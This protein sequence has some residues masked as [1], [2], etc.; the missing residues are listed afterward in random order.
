MLGQPGGHCGWS[1]EGR[2]GWAEMEVMSEAEAT[3]F[4]ARRGVWARLRAGKLTLAVWNER[5][6]RLLC[7]EQS[8][9]HT[10]GGRDSSEDDDW[11]WSVL[12]WIRV[13]AVKMRRED[14]IWEAFWK[15]CSQ[16]LLADQIGLKEKEVNRE[17]LLLWALVTGS[18]LVPFAQIGRIR[19]E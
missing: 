7:R 18:M 12:T 19:A 11:G 5:S 1:P 3:S 8:V 17:L 16:S 15:N 2:E 13:S 6:L 9:G 14:R 4:K 10:C